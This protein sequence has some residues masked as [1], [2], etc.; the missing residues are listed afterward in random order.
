MDYLSG[1]YDELTSVDRQRL[2]QYRYQV[3]VERLGWQLST[4]ADFEFDQFDHS[5]THYIVAEQNDG[6]IKGCARLLPTTQPYLLSEVFT[7]L[8]GGAPAPCQDDIW[9]LSRFTSLDLD[10]QTSKFDQMSDENTVG[11]FMATLD[12]A[13]TCGVSHLVSVSPVAI[14][15]LLKRGGIDFKWLAPP[16]VLDNRALVACCITVQ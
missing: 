8:L 16:Q 14:G 13:K 5:G 4:P 1:R 7:S 3:F 9:E 15:R 6:S 11:L 10:A 12:Y 2:A